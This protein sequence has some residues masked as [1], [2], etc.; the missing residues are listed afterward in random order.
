MQ[1]FSDCIA[2]WAKELQWENDY[3]SFLQW[4][5]LEGGGHLYEYWP[6]LKQLSLIV[7]MGFGT[8]M[9]TVVSVWNAM[10]SWFCVRPS[11]KRWFLK[12]VQVTMKHDP[13]DAI[14]ESMSTWHPSSCIHILCRSLKR[15]VKRTWTN[16][17][18]ST[19]ESAWSAMFPYS[20]SRLWSGPELD[21][22]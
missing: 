7:L 17:A 6:S 4:F 11:S 5:I 21:L 1:L 10:V 20:Q 3:G 15:S 9:R 22:S 2:G 8:S 19:N 18:F 16:S 14:W 13:F 12:L